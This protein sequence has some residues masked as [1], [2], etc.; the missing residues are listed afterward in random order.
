MEIS[1]LRMALLLFYSVIFGGIA[2]AFYD[3]TVLLRVF[4]GEERDGI[5]AERIRNLK[6]PILKHPVSLKKQKLLVKL[7]VFVGDLLC[8]LLI[9]IGIV[10]L[11]YGYNS[12]EFRMFTVFGTVGGFF[13][14]RCTI[15]R[16]MIA[17]AEPLVLLIKYLFLSFFIIFGY[18][19]FKIWQFTVKKLRKILFL[20]S[21]T[22]E[23]KRRKVY[24]VKEKVCLLKMAD[25]GFL[26]PLRNG[27]EDKK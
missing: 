21:F 18:P 17:V 2:G 22:L 4:L 1:P 26:Y 24:N 20:Y 13:A 11:N 27:D 10:A 15:G 25:F 9:S 23:K 12:G 6:L 3:V 19:F 7:A 8:I 14:Y 5:A 16:L